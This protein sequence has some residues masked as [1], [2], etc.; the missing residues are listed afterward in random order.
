MEKSKKILFVV[1]IFIISSLNL[2]AINSYAVSESNNSTNNSGVNNSNYTSTS[3][4]TS[5]SNTTVT[6]DKNESNSEISTTSTN[7]KSSNANLSNL[8]IKPNDFS[9]FKAS[10]TSYNVTVPESV[11][12][13][14]IYATAQDSKATVS[15]T[16]NKKLETGK[17]TVT[18]TVTAEDGTKKTYT[19]N[20]TRGKT[21]E[22]EEVST[23][24]QSRGL[25]ELKI[26][27]L[28]LS[29]EFETN[30]YEYTVKYIGEDTKLDITTVATDEDYIVEVTGN[31]DLKEGENI[32]TILVSDED[33]N[34]VA[35]YQVIV[36][37]SLVDEE[38][39][40]REQAEKERKNKIIIGSIV[41][42]VVVLAII[43]VL[44]VRHRRNK[45][46]DDEYWETE[47]DRNDLFSEENIKDNN[48]M[49][50]NIDNDEEN[51]NNEDVEFTEVKGETEED[52]KEALKRKFLDN[53]NSNSYDDYDDLE[54]KPRRKRKG[55]RFK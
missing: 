36:N 30:V 1:I 52:E 15:G 6:T 40:Q 43:I 18:V 8:G 13:I 31:E 2:F 22:S 10:V 29:P 9:G 54:E 35:I 14:S 24:V 44:I 28:T 47:E 49:E 42:A 26:A 5:K 55:K 51:E 16:G 39:L 4:N 20:I 19:I 21:E 41:A 17:N 45:Y 7:K 37:K 11:E 27:N 12:E 23:D 50:D 46:Y 53:Y 38:A 48:K 32:I 33:G 34:N 3:T 25:S